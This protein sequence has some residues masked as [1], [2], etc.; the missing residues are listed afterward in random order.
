[1]KTSMRKTSLLHFAAL[2]ATFA[3]ALL[4]SGC[5]GEAKTP[6]IAPVD[7]STL[8]PPPSPAAKLPARAGGATLTGS[9]SFAGTAPV[10]AQ[11]P[12]SG[13][14]YCETMHKGKALLEDA[15]I[16]GKSGELANVFVYVKG[17]AGSY[18]APSDH[19]LL[20]QRGCR[21]YPHVQGIQSGQTLDVK[22]SDDTLHNVHA[23]PKDNIPFNQG[24]PM[25]MTSDT[26]FTKVETTPF[27]VKCD[28]HGWMK[29][30]LAVMPDPFFAVSDLDG[31]FTIPNLP[32]GTYTVVAWHEK[33][34]AQQQQ[35]TI[36]AGESKPV[37]FSFHG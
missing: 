34:G 28:V 29:S 2:A 1:M 17:V 35:I 15:V 23:M 5:G 9:V 10:R 30:Y 20:D 21:Y 11:I 33:Y 24:Q 7:E 32:P 12:L 26:T 18:T 22:N 16:V 3:A 37:A 25:P 6:S 4:V 31:K 19:A 8:I 27:L 36:G 14:P 13:D